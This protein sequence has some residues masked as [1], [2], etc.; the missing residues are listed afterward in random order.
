MSAVVDKLVSFA[1]LLDLI[2][3]KALTLAQAVNNRD[4]KVPVLCQQLRGAL[5]VVEASTSDMR[6]ELN[7]IDGGP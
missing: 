2:R 4:A 3:A 7:A 6:A 5:D 1:S